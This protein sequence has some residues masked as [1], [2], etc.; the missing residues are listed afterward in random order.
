MRKTELHNN[1]KSKAKKELGTNSSYKAQIKI[2][3]KVAA[4]GIQAIKLTLNETA[5]DQETSFRN[6]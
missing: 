6:Q 2:H 3:N 1:T 5:K 4:N